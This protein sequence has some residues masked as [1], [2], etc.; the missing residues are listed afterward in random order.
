[1]STKFKA[2][3]ILAAV[4]LTLGGLSIGTTA[5]AA[6]KKAGKADVKDAK[7]PT[8]ILDNFIKV[9]WSMAR[10]NSSEVKVSQVAGPGGSALR[11]SYDLKNGKWIAVSK[12]FAI[13]DFKGKAISFQMKSKGANN[14]L[15]VKLVD[16]DGTNYGVKRPVLTESED[17]T[18][19]NLSEADF[20]YW[21]GGDPA[22]GSIKAIYFAVS[23]GDGGAGEVMVANL[24]MGKASK[25]GHI[26]KGG[27]IFDGQSKEGWMVAKGEGS[28]LALEVGPGEKGAKAMAMKYTI[29]AGQ[30]VSIRRNLSADLSKAT[31]QKLVLRMKGEGDPCDVEIKVID[32]D[33]STFG[34]LLSGA[35]GSGE[36]TDVIIPLSEF[37]Y[38]WGGDSE[39]DSSLVRYLDIAISGSGGT[40]KVLVGGIRLTK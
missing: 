19:I 15:E 1:M 39:L 7:A 17:W 25:E 6:E 22:L 23:A 2:S 31:D 3:S 35:A 27:L 28:S 9:D 29:P 36:W 18:T 26:G 21:W 37:A 16:E 24:Q 12:G 40:G 33:D 11:I 38:M 34:K 20:S 30:W 10:D 32:R 5:R 8:Q 14:N 4:C 13:D